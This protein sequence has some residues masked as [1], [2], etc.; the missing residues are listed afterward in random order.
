ME[1]LAKA[2]EME[3]NARY[4]ENDYQKVAD[5]I[6]QNSRYHHS[7]ILI[8]WHHGEI[9]ELAAAS[10]VDANKLPPESLGRTSDWIAPVFGAWKCKIF[11]SSACEF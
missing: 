1:P 11:S 9:L 6:L 8:C 3:I 10:G 4:Q 2:M 7:N 5:D